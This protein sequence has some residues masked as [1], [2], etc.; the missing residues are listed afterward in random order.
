MLGFIMLALENLSASYAFR[1]SSRSCVAP[2]KTS[3]TTPDGPDVA[4][5]NGGVTG[6]IRVFVPLISGPGPTDT[7]GELGAKYPPA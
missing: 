2:G 6:Q 5:G 4:V 7:P 3:D 1:C